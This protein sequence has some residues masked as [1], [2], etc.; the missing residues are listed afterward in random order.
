MEQK[1]QHISKKLLT[2]T[3]NI[4]KKKRKK[5]KILWRDAISHSEWLSPSEA[6]L[7]KPAINTTEGYLLE[8]NKESTIVYMSYNDTDV[9]DLTV[10]PTENI[11]SFK[12]V[13]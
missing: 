4:R 8:K 6:K 9:G 5:V 1:I 3:K 7:Y 10:I 13:R 2:F 12:F 11:K